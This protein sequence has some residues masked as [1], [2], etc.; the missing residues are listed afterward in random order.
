MYW[1][2]PTVESRSRLAPMPNSRS[3]PTVTTPDSA[4]S[5]NVT[6][7]P[8]AVRPPAA[9]SQTAT[10]NAKGIKSAH[11]RNRAESGSTGN[12]LRNRP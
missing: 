9:A 12:R 4:S 3:G 1:S 7:S 10:A 5:S 6:G 8:S 2:R 11:S